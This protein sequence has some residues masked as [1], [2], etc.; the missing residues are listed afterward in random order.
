[1]VPNANAHWLIPRDTLESTANKLART[2]RPVKEVY[3]LEIRDGFRGCWSV[4][5]NVVQAN[6]LNH[7]S[8][9]W[10]NGGLLG[11]GCLIH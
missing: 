7:F 3:L 2:I 1:M 5:S 10:R 9:P 4:S 11:A 8:H 6:R